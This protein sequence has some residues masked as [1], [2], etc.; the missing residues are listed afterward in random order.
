MNKIKYTL[1]AAVTLDGKIAKNSSHFTDWTSKED[2]KFMQ[3]ELNKSDV[4]IV[5]NNTFQTAKKPLSKRN[6]IV[7]NHKIKEKKENQ[8]KN[9]IF[10]NPEKT[11]IKKIITK[12]N[13]KKICILGG[14]Q[15]YSFF[16]RKNLIDEMFITIEPLIFGKGLS[17]FDYQKEKKFKLISMKKLNKKGSLLLHY[18]K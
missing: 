5:G 2:K 3:K 1:I 16:L 6:C 11:E 8:T 13:Y 17:L 9:L 4:I 18:K 14:M 10:I 12:N 7:L 15:T